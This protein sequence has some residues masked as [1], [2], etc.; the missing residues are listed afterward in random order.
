M[1]KENLIKIYERSFIDN[2]EL[3]VLTD[4][5]TGERLTYGDFARNI[6]RLHLRS[7]RALHPQEVTHALP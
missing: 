1:I 6:A 4:Y 5:N 7:Q 2:W 3:P